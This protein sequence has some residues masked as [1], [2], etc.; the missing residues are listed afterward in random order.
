MVAA[1][2]NETIF[3][4]GYEDAYGVQAPGELARIADRIRQAHRFSRVP[5][6]YRR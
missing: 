3:I 4:D 5:E 1:S 2:T 6:A